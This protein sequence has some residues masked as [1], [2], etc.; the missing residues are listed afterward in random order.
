[1]TQR[2][3]ILA[4]IVLALL[5]VGVGVVGGYMFILSPLQEKER[6]AE[7]LQNEVDDLEM[8]V[9]SMRKAAPQVAA[10]KRASLPPDLSD[11]KDP[12]RIPTFNFARAEYKRLIERLLINAGITDGKPGLDKLVVMRPP[13]TPEMSPKKP[14]YYTLTFDI[15]MNKVNLWQVVD[16]LYGYYQVDL[17]H[18]ITDISITRENRANEARGGLKVSITSEA[19]ALNGVEPR[20]SLIPV[21]SSI[22]AV[23]GAPALQAIAARP[24]MVHRLLRSNALASRDRDYSYIAWG[25]IFYGVVPTYIPPKP[26][27]FELARLDNVTMARD[28]QPK[29]VKLQLKGD[30]VVGAKVTAKASGS[31]IKEGA[32]TVDYDAGT[33]TIPAVKPDV[34]DSATSTVEVVAV[35]AD[36]TTKK[37]SFTVAVEKL[38]PGP[39]IASA[40]RLV[41][42]SLGSDGT[43]SATIKDN[44]TPYRYLIDSTAKGIIVRRE[45]QVHGKKWDE[46]GAY[47]R[48]G[49]PG[50]L[51]IKDDDSSTKRTFKIIA[52]EHNALIVC[53]ISAPDSTPSESKQPP[54]PGVGI[55]PPGSPAKQGPAE[56]ISAVAGAITNAIPKPLYYRWAGGKSLKEL[57]DPSPK[58]TNRLKPDEVNEILRRVAADGPVGPVVASG[59]E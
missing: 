40:I 45:Y 52:F 27:P 19:I 1:M 41:I 55:R 25:D 44:A 21:T 54:K 16:F 12:N 58:N 51:T 22:A 8:K 46:E 24:E 20:T 18:Q 34:A 50:V 10:I 7:T 2:E 6:A 48:N 32:L 31:L 43:A 5:V 49:K 26:V 14:A 30:G 28:E 39:D 29:D 57:L 13:I 37:E 42:V 47:R 33:I 38:P 11:S 4:I 9:L 59:N 15:E 56:A 3:R 23:A 17:L 36:G 53:D 35:S